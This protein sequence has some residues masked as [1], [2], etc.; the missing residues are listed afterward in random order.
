MEYV[1]AVRGGLAV[2]V[3][4][5]TA[6]P[7]RAEAGRSFFGWLFPTEVMPERQV[8]LQTWISE[9]NKNADAADR[10]L[11]IWG[12]A[13]MVGIT[14]RLELVMPFEMM[15]GRVP[16]MPG[17]TVMH[18]YGVEARY[19]FV[20]MD[21]EEAP[22]FA[23]LVRLAVRRLVLTR[24]VVRPEVNVVGSYEI[25]SVFVAVDVGLLADISRED[26]HLQ[27]RPGLGVS[28]NVAG[29]LRVGAEAFAQISLDDRGSTWAVVGPNMSWTHG[30]F[31]VSATYGVGVHDIKS[32]PRMQWGIAF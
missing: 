14:D 23:P 6:L 22:P 29:D 12:A 19:R 9:E 32:A 31:W 26:T 18:N 5:V 20:T 16:G 25:D 17:F 1:R 3:A 13:P 7:A 27:L 24:D 10:S 15:W 30:R 4:V 2:L 28:V 8:E 11:S 21:R